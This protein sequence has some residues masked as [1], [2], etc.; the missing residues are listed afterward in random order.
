MPFPEIPRVT[1]EKSALE[2]MKCQI[3]F[4]PIISIDSP[5]AAF[6]EAVRQEFPYYETQTSVRMPVGLPAGLSQA[7]QTEAAAGGKSHR[8]ISEDRKLTVS[9]SRNDLT[10]TSRR[11]RRWEDFCSLLQGG[12]WGCRMYRGRHLCS[13]QLAAFWQSQ[14]LRR[15]TRFRVKFC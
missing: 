11:Y 7:F 8:F 15:W 2:E 3:R 6:Q 4:P 12:L 14:R 9:L 13:R 10:I 1:Y 5:P